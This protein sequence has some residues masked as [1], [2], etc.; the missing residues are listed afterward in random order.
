MLIRSIEAYVEKDMKK[1]Q[2][3][4]RHDDI[5]DDLFDKNKA[6]I[7]E[8]IRHD[9][10]KGE[11]ATDMLM[12]AKYFER[13]GDHATNIAEWVIFAL[14]DKKSSRNPDHEEILHKFYIND[15]LDFTCRML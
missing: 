15:T 4:I 3:V 8:L 5:V 7:I 13:I 9:P 10:E 12:V 1:A 14:D 2:E 11:Q 6:D